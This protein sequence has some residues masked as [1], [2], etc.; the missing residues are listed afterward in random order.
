MGDSSR[1]DWLCINTLRTLAMDAVQAANSGH[2]GTPMAL[3]PVA[4]CLW[5]R[6]LHYDPQEPLWPNRDRFV[7][8]NGHASMLLYGLL[9]LAQVRAADAGDRPLAE[10]AVSLADI[11]AFRQLGSRCPGHP[12]YGLT[13]GVECTTGPLGTGVATSVGMAAGGRW[14]GAHFNRPGADLFDFDV[15]AFCGDGDLMEGGSHEAASLAGHLKLANLCWVYDSNHISIEGPTSLA[16]SEDVP[17]RFLSYGWRVREI[18]DANDLDAL[19]AAF[20]AFREERGRPLLLVVHSHIGYGA[21]H[22]HDSARAHGEPLG[23][24]EVRL[25]KRSYGWP[26]DAHFLVPDGVREHFAAHLGERGRAQR[27]RWQSRLERYRATWPELAADLERLQRRELTPGWEEALPRFPA[28]PKGLPT[29]ASSGDVLQALAAR[30]PWLLGG[31]ADLA[32]STRTHLDAEEELEA[33][34]PGARNL[35]F[36][37]REFA[38]GCFVNGLALCRLRPFGATFLIFS[39]YMRPAIRLAALMDL[40]SLFIFTHDSIGLGED[41][42]THQPVEQLVALRAIPGLLVLRPADAAEVVECWR[43][44]LAE[45]CSPAALVLTRQSVPTFDR[46]RLASAR[47][48]E[49]G[50]YV[51]ADTDAGEPEVLLLA[52]GSEVSLC[53]AAHEVLCEEGVRSRVVSMPCWELF[54]RQPKAYRDAVLPPGVGARVAVEQASTVG[55]AH[56]V[57]HEGTIIG[58]HTFGASAPLARLLRKFGFTPERIAE[59]A[60]EQLAR[61]RR[62]F[63]TWPEEAPPAPM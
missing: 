51:L 20:R 58:M 44:L 33:G 23:E 57:G 52:T 50:A 34:V 31:A 3:A 43:A 12:E 24:D 15:F 49:R 38:M 21:P 14:L 32:P 9:H 18:P 41:G 26:E 10:P 11:E 13:T 42:P 36:G 47:G 5:Q 2:P 27:E 56:Y 29:R 53:L 62:T 45:W 4:Y 17:G 8:S 63:A 39:D 55:W 6:Y 61:V 7:L 59:A 48:V 54:E 1:L 19:D 37:V 60:R 25:A 30:V 46:S 28:D 40:P 22:L 16:F 35:H